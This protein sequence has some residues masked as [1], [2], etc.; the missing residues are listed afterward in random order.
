M[1]CQICFKVPEVPNMSKVSKAMSEVFEVPGAVTLAG[2]G[3]GA[4]AW[5]GALS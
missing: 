1:R 4:G 2:A 5:V 3:L